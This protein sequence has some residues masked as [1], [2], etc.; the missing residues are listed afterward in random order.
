MVNH[1][2]QGYLRVTTAMKDAVKLWHVVVAFFSV[3][4]YIIGWMMINLQTTQAAETSHQDIIKQ[5]TAVHEE[6]KDEQFKQSHQLEDQSKQIKDL[7]NLLKTKIS[8]DNL[9]QVNADIRANDA[10]TFQLQQWIKVNGEDAQS[11]KR[12]NNLKIEREEL[13]V[14]RNCIIN[15]NGMCN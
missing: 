8:Q 3:A 6:I 5:M 10:E 7:T 14:K 1:L 13:V 12:L 11:A 15:G 9:S 4:A 2:K